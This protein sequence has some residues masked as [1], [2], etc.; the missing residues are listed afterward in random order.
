MK[1][2]SPAAPNATPDRVDEVELDAIFERVDQCSKPGVAV[3]LA[4]GG[5]PVYRK[6]FGLASMDTPLLLDTRMRMRVGSI[7]KQF[8]ALAYLLLCEMSQAGL[9]DRLGRYFP[10]FHPVVRDITM[11][12][13]M[14]HTSGVRDV[15]SIRFRL[16]GFEGTSIPLKTLLELYTD[17]DDVDF[18]PGVTCA[19]NNGGY[20]ILGAAI[21]RITRQR[22]GEVLWQRIFAPIGMY[23]SFLRDWDTEFFA[24]AATAH[25]LTGNGQFERRYW[26][27]DF[28][29]AGN[30]C[31]TADDLLRWLIHMDTPIVGTR[32]TW[33]LMTT[34]NTLPNGTSTG[35]GFGLHQG[36]YRGLR[37]VS[38]GGGWIGGNAMILKVPERGVDI[39]VISNRNDVYSPVLVNRVL[40]L[41]IF[42]EDVNPRSDGG[43]EYSVYRINRKD[44]AVASGAQTSTAPVVTGIFRAPGSRRIVQLF[45]RGGRQI[46]SVNAHDLPYE[47][48]G[49]SEMVPSEAWSH[50]KRTVTLLGDPASPSSIVL[51]DFGD[52]EDFV[53]VV[54]SNDSDWESILGEYCWAPAGG[55]ARIQR[56]DEQL[57]LQTRSRFGSMSY[58]LERLDRQIWRASSL[59]SIFLDS[60]LFFDRD[61]EGFHL[62]SFSVRSL[63]FRRTA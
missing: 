3:A 24:N 29:G 42:G 32:A 47:R 8:T 22:L 5:T 44:N 46:V 33:G 23:D 7:T 59:A 53:A 55:V 61:H 49:E 34:P 30:L 60:I 45:G 16:G 21:E 9:D 41:C 15:S 36:S 58:V 17:I 57:I 27:V 38:H 50:I 48:R 28:G 20:M 1:I 11:R 25:T 52:V 54:P 12:Q 39:A 63:A 31:S 6:G 4:I 51:S 37:T 14:S 35:Y 18:K 40:D 10:E 26:G 56:T 2:S 19:Y 62:T 43:E 13:L